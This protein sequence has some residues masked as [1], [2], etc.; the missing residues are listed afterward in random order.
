MTTYASP[1]VGL[2]SV[3]SGQWLDA[4][5]VLASDYFV[6]MAPE[7]ERVLRVS[8]QLIC[9]TCR[10]DF[11]PVLCPPERLC[12]VCRQPWRIAQEEEA[13]HASW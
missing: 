4:G 3:E 9:R 12:L 5:S 13:D 7:G 1:L 8:G 11:Q 2:I 10:T 6:P